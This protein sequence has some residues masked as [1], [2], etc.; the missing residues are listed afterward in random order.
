VLILDEPT[1]SLSDRE[2]ERLF[3]TILNLKARGIGIIYISHRIHEFDRIAD[4]ITVLRD[5]KLCATVAGRG[6]SEARLVE[7]MTG[8]SIAE[9]Y[10]SIAEKPEAAILDVEGLVAAGVDGVSLTVRPGQV[11]GCAGLVGSGKSRLWR[12]ILGL[13]AKSAGR[14]VFKGRDITRAPTRTVIAAGLFYLPPDRKA[15][16]LQL[17]APAASNLV[18]GPIGSD[19]LYGRF[20]LLSRS[21]ARARVA[22]I[23]TEVG[24]D[25]DHLGRITSQLSGGNQQKLLFGKGFGRAFD[26]YVLDEPTVGVDMGTRAA[27]YQLVKR[28]T[29]SG[30]AVV[31][32]SSALPEVMNLSHRLLVF[33][34]GRIAAELTG[35][36]IEEANI[37]GHFFAGGQASA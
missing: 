11:L 9:I 13:H 30:K 24:L 27:L 29:E 31:I 20:G 2:T 26:L 19:E 10:P 8:R 17:S 22:T 37:L 12:A 34:R 5:G 7:L 33:S 15:E 21:R 25:Q 16:G 1:A 14:V 4:R 6:T 23:A 3:A 28:L 32:I 36:D 18:A 35:A